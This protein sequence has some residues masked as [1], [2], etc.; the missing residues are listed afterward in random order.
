MY[1]RDFRNRAGQRRQRRQRILLRG[2]VSL[3]KIDPLYGH[4][5]DEGRR[6][7]PAWSEPFGEIRKHVLLRRLQLLHSS[8]TVRDLVDADRGS[9]RAQNDCFCG[10]LDQ[11]MPR[12]GLL[13]YELEY[14]VLQILV[15]NAVVIQDRD[16]RIRSPDLLDH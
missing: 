13:R 2:N 15:G 14:A 12:D 6:A 9:S 8:N 16:V 7:R 1:D 10:I 5:I 11:D 4:R 3:N